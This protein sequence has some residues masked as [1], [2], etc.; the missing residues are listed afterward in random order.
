[1]SNV[2]ICGE[3]FE[4]NRMFDAHKAVCPVNQGSSKDEKVFINKKQPIF[5]PVREIDN[6]IITFMELECSDKK[7]LSDLYAFILEHN[8]TIKVNEMNSVAKSVLM[9][10]GN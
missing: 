7:V 8:D 3:T 2:C 9:M 10:R 5:Q 4:S 1:M 6:A